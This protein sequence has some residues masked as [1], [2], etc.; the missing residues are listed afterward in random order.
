MCLVC[1]VGDAVELAGQYRAITLQRGGPFDIYVGDD[2]DH[3]SPDDNLTERT[4]TQ[5]REVVAR[6]A[7]ASGHSAG[8]P[9]IL[10][11]FDAGYDVTRLAWLFPGTLTRGPK[12]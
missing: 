3:N 7:D 1:L 10:V 11:V 12:G 4:A 5:V 2:F 8:D 9:P 6:L